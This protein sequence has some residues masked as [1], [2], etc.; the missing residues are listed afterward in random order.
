[1][2][3]EDTGEEVTCPYCN[4]ED[5]C[6]HLLATIDRTFGGIGNGYACGRQDELSKEIEKAFMARAINAGFPRSGRTN[7]KL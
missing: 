3:N 2:H 1:M 6:P 4:Q 7:E 5:S